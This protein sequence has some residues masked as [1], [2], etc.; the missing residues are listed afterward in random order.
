MIINAFKKYGRIKKNCIFPGHAS[1]G[2]NSGGAFCRDVHQ[3]GTKQE[4]EVRAD[5]LEV[6]YVEST[7][8]GVEICEILVGE[9]EKLVTSAL[10]SEKQLKMVVLP[11]FVK[12]TIPH[13]NDIF[14]SF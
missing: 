1:T 10:V 13:F 8:K 9:N 7:G 5:D 3:G 14:L 11:I 4:T 6:L 12:P 2:V